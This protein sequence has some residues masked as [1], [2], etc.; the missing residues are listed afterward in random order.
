MA[1]R[2]AWWGCASWR[3]FGVGLDADEDGGHVGAID[4]RAD[5]FH[6]AIGVTFNTDDFGAGG[7]GHPRLQVGGNVDAIEDVLTAGAPLPAHDE[8]VV[9][10]VADAGGVGVAEFG[11]LGGEFASVAQ[12][13]EPEV[14]G[15]VA[16]DGVVGEVGGGELSPAPLGKAGGG[17]GVA[18]V[19][20]KTQGGIA[21][22][23]VAAVG[24]R[25]EQLARLG[26]AR[27]QHGLSE[28]VGAAVDDHVVEVLSLIHIY[29]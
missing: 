23:V 1:Q 28:G 18:D 12:R 20:G 22:Q 15:G 11:E 5:G 9:R 25:V 16:A 3:L 27:V 7:V 10:G 19:A 21:E 17:G 14:F 24:V 8:A 4:P 2:G 26:A 6:H 29:L 13:V